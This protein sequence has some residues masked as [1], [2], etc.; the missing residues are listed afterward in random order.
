MKLL[1]CLLAGMLSLSLAAQKPFEGTI[2][3]KLLILPEADTVGFTISFAPG[4]VLVQVNSDDDKRQADMLI[5]LDS[6]YVHTL[7]TGSKTYTS[8]KLFSQENAALTPPLNKTI[9]GRATTGVILS[10]G[11]SE[12]EGL[13][14]MAET[15][16]VYPANDLL[17]PV[18]EKYRKNLELMYIHQNHILLGGELIIN[19][20]R[21]HSGADL[22][23]RPRLVFEAQE[24]VARPVPALRNMLKEYA[25]LEDVEV[26]SDSVNAIADGLMMD[27]VT[28]IDTVSA[29][30]YDIPPPPPP[31]KK[32]DPA[33]KPVKKPATKTSGSGTKKQAARKPE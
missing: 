19:E 7:K 25:Q 15:A 22:A 9:L 32:E 10:N 17:F 20:R 13:L 30:Y 16:V 26:S 27:S 21:G 4:R 18:P 2:R 23:K 33:K 11:G 8:R 29:T 12:Y 3:Y 1:F 5:D 24:I 14:G 28:V 31:A 6:G